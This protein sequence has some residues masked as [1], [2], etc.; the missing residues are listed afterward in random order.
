M[1]VLLSDRGVEDVRE[2]GWREVEREDMDVFL[3]WT[4]YETQDPFD[5][6]FLFFLVGIAF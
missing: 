5:K 6:I 4:V 3:S 1:Q 2:K